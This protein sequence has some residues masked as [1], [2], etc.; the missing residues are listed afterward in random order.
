MDDKPTPFEAMKLAIEIAGGQ[1]ATARICEVTQPA[2]WKWL[3]SA[4]KVPPLFVLK[5]EAATGVSRHL[6]RPDIYP[7]SETAQDIDPGEECGG[8]L[9]VRT[10][11]VACDRIAQLQR[12]DVA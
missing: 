4:K 8:I 9:P 2:V 6:L 3:Q 1:S 11:T 7:L 10:A 5:L 12:K